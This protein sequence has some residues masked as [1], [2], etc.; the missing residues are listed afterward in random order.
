MRKDQLVAKCVDGEINGALPIC[1]MCKK[2]C[3]QISSDKDGYEI[4]TCP[5]EGYQFPFRVRSDYPWPLLR[6]T[7]DCAETFCIGFASSYE[8][9]ELLIV[10]TR[11][12]QVKTV[13]ASN[14]TRALYA[15]SIA[16]DV[17]CEGL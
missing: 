4:F 12:T 11:I 16:K 10:W 5:G 3:V 2:A 7:L 1:P 9:A 17:Q 13:P 14:A 6:E 8:N 15:N